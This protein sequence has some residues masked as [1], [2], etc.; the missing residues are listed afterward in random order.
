MR[1]SLRPL[2]SAWGEPR[3]LPGLAASAAQSIPWTLL[4]GLCLV[5][6]A[7]GLFGHGPWRGDD[8]FGV[9]L[10]RQVLVAWFDGQ[11]TGLIPNLAGSVVGRD[12]PLPGW[13]MAS[14]IAPFEALSRWVVGHGISARWFDDL[15]RLASGLSLMIGLISLWKATDRL[16]RR[17][18]AQPTDPLGIGPSAQS[19]GRTLGDCS[20][21][22]ALACLGSITKWHEA[23]PAAVSFMVTALLC[24][25]LALAPEHPI[26]SGRLI[27]LLLAALTL[28]DGPEAGLA[29]ALGLSMATRLAQP[30]RLASARLVREAL[31]TLTLMLTLF[32]ALAWFRAPALL[33]EWWAH[34]MTWSAPEPVQALKTWAWTWWPMWPIIAVLWVQATKHRLWQLPHIQLVSVLVGVISVMALLGPG[35]LDT[36][37]FLP[38]APLAILAAFGLLSMPRSLTSLLDWFAVVVFTSLGSLIWLYWSAMSFG[39]PQNL[40]SRLAVF[41]P[42]LK[43]PM[44]GPLEVFFGVAIS[45]AWIILVLWRI[46]RGRPRLWRPVVLSAGGLILAWILMMSLWMPALDINRGYNHLLPRLE[47]AALGVGD[48]IQT[49]A[50]DRTSRALVMASQRLQLG[51]IGQDQQCGLLLVQVGPQLAAAPSGAKLIWTGQRAAD[52]KDRERYLLYRLTDRK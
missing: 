16:A 39:F 31:I 5:Y 18:E 2:L 41:A 30:W 8:L 17:R 40:A 45:G 28:T 26:R 15:C 3:P 20:V 22:I 34:Q 14:L 29:W 11:G 4:L 23:G 38:V 35:L 32:V 37:Q 33:S 43:N 36:R 6:M 47:R 42:G 7:F 46:R 24:W 9:A 1:S 44:P 12:G 21:L 50:D 48:C 13:W 51:S 10:A 19:L 49:A 25:A 52:R 27:G